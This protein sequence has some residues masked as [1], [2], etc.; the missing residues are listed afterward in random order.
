ML[1]LFEALKAQYIKEESCMLAVVVGASGS[2]P[3]E[4]GAYMLVNA[5]GRIWGTVGGGATEYEATQ[6]AQ[7]QLKLQQSKLCHYDLSPVADK[8]CGGAQDILL[9]YI[10]MAQEASR[11]ALA[12]VFEAA[13]SGQ[14]FWLHIPLAEGAMQA[15]I[16]SKFDDRADIEPAE[17]KNAKLQTFY[18][19]LFNYDGTVYIF[20]GGH[21]AQELVPVLAHLDFRCIVLDDRE[22]FANPGLFPNAV[23][24]LQVNYE[25]LEAQVSLTANDYACIMTRAHTYDAEC[26]RFA[27]KSEAGYIGIMGSKHKAKLT[28]EKL[29]SEGFTETDISRVITPIGISLPC[30]TPAEIA[31]SI[32]A[33]LIEVRANKRLKKM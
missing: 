13:A 2:T 18:S 9:H 4:A 19:E 3:R 6:K 11:N 30:E 21:V 5:D 17:A 28:R 26:E 29:L 12:E 27:L 25:H 31:I 22:E 1:G 14:A 8:L 23:Q 16:K 15:V 24:C 32:A 10:D 7:E 20:G 33:Q